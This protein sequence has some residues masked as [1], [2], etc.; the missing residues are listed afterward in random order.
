MKQIVTVSGLVAQVCDCHYPLVKD[1]SWYPMP[2]N[3]EGAGIKWKFKT[4]MV[5]DGKMKQVL[6]HRLIMG[7]PKGVIDHIDG[8]AQN[9]QCSNLRVTD[10]TRNNFNQHGPKKGSKSGYKGVYW[11]KAAQ[12]WCAE[13]VYNHHKHYLGLFDDVK[14]A[15]RAYNVKAL[16]IDPDFAYLNVLD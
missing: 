14:D 11:H 16:E 12:K 7:F 3:R 5:I 15:A 2:S 10:Q 13:V 6:M 4:F 9:N 1:Y 8:D